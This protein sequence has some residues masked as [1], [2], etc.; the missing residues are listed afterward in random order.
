MVTTLTKA[1]KEAFEKY[2]APIQEHEKEHWKKLEPKVVK[3]KKSGKRKTYV[4]KSFRTTTECGDDDSDDAGDDADDDGGD[5]IEVPLDVESLAEA[6]T[7]VEAKESLDIWSFGTI[8]Y[9]L[10]VGHPLFPVDD[11]NDDLLGSAIQDLFNWTDEKKEVRL[12]RL[13]R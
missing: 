2:Y 11:R 5:P 4:I 8:M 13:S 1:Q 10:C 3:N 12:D 9:R 6:Y 7:L